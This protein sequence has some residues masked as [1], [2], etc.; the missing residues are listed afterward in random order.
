MGLIARILDKIAGRPDPEKMAQMAEEVKQRKL[1]YKPSS[2]TISNQSPQSWAP[3]LHPNGMEHSSYIDS[4]DY[5]GDSKK[6]QV[7]FT[8]GFSAEY[9]NISEDDA[10]SFNSADSKGRFFNNHFKNMPYKEV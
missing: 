7:S 5:D 4:I 10:K 6:M 8:N 1:S 9:D 2:L 3:D